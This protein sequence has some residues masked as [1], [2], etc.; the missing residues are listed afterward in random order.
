VSRAIRVGIDYTSAAFQSAGIG[1]HTRC[2]VRALA[3]IDHT[4]QYRLLVQGRRHTVLA[5]TAGSSPKRNRVSGIPNPNF[6]EVRTWLNERWWTRI[7]HR[8]RLPIAVDWL[9]GPIDVFHSP[10]F[11]LPPV[12]RRTRTVVTIH[13]L[14]FVRLPQCFEPSLAKYLNEHVPRAIGRADWVLADSENTRQDAIELLRAPA[15]RTTVIYPGVEPRFCPID[16]AAELQRVRSK[17]GLPPRF[18]LSVGTVQPRKN[19]GQLIKA[20]AQAELAEVELVVFGRKG[21][22]YKDILTEASRLGIQHKVHFA[23]FIDD[24]DLPLAYNLAD[25]FAFPSLYE[26]FGIPPLEAMACGTPVICADNSSLPEVVGDAGLLVDAQ[27]TAAWA[28][29]LDKATHDQELRQTM[30]ARG[31]Q[32]AQRF[33]WPRA[34]QALL[35]VYK[36]LSPT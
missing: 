34:G 10:D 33:N 29:A 17:Y 4:N 16:S 12:G 9:T 13:D 28:N 31:L 20:F 6:A 21:W 8:L 18:V 14:S 15:D 30:R 35:D 25:C 7:W 27:D 23:G 19:Y 24:Q 36:S 26:G 11:T 32:R 3:E 2:T 5:Q 1:R 22:L